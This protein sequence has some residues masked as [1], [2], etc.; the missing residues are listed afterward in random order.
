M[1]I[2]KV[3]NM[4][5]VEVALITVSGIC[6]GTNVHVSLFRLSM[7]YVWFIQTGLII[8]CTHVTTQWHIYYEG[9]DAAS[10]VHVH[11]YH[12]HILPNIIDF[13]R[14]RHLLLA[15]PILLELNNKLSSVISSRL[16]HWIWII[17]TKY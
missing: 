5:L 8:K 17:S 3:L 10:D 13:H 7:E 6:T 16:Y 12:P 15:K 14:Q 2:L 9:I 11:A 4:L 1:C